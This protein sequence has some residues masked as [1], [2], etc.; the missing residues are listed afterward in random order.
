[1]K[2]FTGEILFGTGEFYSPHGTTPPDPT[3]MVSTSGSN[4]QNNDGSNIVQ[5]CHHTGGQGHYLTVRAVH[6]QHPNSHMN[7]QEHP[8]TLRAPDPHGR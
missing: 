1:M 4:I 6:M 2:G 7:S 8:G 3:C 5:A